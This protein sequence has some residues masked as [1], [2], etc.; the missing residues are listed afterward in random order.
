MREEIME[1]IR[2]HILPL[3][4]VENAS[5]LEVWPGHSRI[6]I[7][8]TES[9]LNLYGNL[10]G[11]FIFTLCDITS[12]MAA[13]A[14]EYANVTQHGNIDFLKGI[15]SGQIF[16][17]SNAIHKGSRSVVNRVEVTSSEGTLLAAGTFTMYLLS[18]L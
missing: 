1:G 8:I 16:V 5:L 7:D 9:A 10:H 17:E 6:S 4:G 13:Y 14:Y 11:G 12:G 18:A 15:S 2:R 3:S